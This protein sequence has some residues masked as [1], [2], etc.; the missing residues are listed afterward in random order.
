[1]Q[2]SAKSES[3]GATE[4]KKKRFYLCRLRRRRH[5]CSLFLLL[6]HLHLHLL[7]LLL[8]LLY[9]RFFCSLSAPGRHPRELQRGS[10]TAVE[11][12]Q[13]LRSP[14]TTAPGRK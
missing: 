2:G 4:K 12:P 10:A 3:S 14:K 1:M 11:S 8:L 7:L 6:F 13:G 5:C 9:L